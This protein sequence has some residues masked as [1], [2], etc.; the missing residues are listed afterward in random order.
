MNALKP[1]P[2]FQVLVMSEESRLGREQIETALMFLGGRAL[3]AGLGGVRLLLSGYYVQALALVRDLL[4]V[5][6]LI[7]WFAAEPADIAVW[8]GA[9]A[10]ERM[11]RFG[12][13]RLNKKLTSRGVP[14]TVFLAADRHI[15]HRQKVLL[16]SS[17]TLC[18]AL[19]MI[20]SGSSCK[21]RTTVT[22]SA[23]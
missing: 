23:N 8:R 16:C 7:Q 10:H 20:C 9:S 15:L 18:I 2:P 14:T 21:W 3:T 13:S 17:K 12:P 11:D 19:R 22:D 4:E 6:L 5:T 1:R